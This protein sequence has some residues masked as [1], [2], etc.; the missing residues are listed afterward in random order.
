MKKISKLFISVLCSLSILTASCSSK[1]ITE[2]DTTENDTVTETETSEEELKN[3]TADEVAADFNANIHVPDL[4]IK[5][6]EN[7][8]YT[9]YWL[10]LGFD[11]SI[12]DSEEN[13]KEAAYILVQFVPSYVELYAEEYFLKLGKKSEYYIAFVTKTFSVAIEIYGFLNV[14]MRCAEVYIYDMVA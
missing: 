10:G 1:K 4:A 11:D 2:D 3:Y 9:G 7:E 13:L 14:G 6:Y 5:Y 8:A 12:D